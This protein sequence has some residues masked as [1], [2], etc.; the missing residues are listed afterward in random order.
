MP[1]ED[2]AM[3]PRCAR[4]AQV[5]LAT[6]CA[7]EA[8]GLAINP[9]NIERASPHHD[10]AGRGVSRRTLYRV[11]YTSLWRPAQEDTAQEVKR[12]R[13]ENAQLRSLLNDY[14]K[15]DA[16]RDRHH[17]RRK[18]LISVMKKRMRQAEEAQDR[19]AGER[20]EIDP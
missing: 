12:L 15:R 1:S 8:T 5:I 11:S 7:L 10:P 3:S 13:A 17:A 19:L 6:C 9:T 18:A 16:R 20:L 14:S 4:T 2:V